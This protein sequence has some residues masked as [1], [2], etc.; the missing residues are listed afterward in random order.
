MVLLDSFI[1]LKN[2]FIKVDEDKMHEKLARNQRLWEYHLKHPDTGCT[3]LGRIFHHTNIKGEQVP[4]NP[5]AVWRILKRM[6]KRQVKVCEAISE[7]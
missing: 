2:I 6:Q 5:S 3:K 7:S 4:L 1:D